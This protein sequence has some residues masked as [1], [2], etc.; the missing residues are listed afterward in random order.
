M[1]D[2]QKRLVREGH[3]DERGAAFCATATQLPGGDRGMVL[4]CVKGN[5]LNI[6]DVDMRNNVK[7]LL[8]QVELK[9]VQN[10]KIRTPLF[11]EVLRFEYQGAV[12]SFKNFLK[13]RPALDVIEEESRKQ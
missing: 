11:I 10:L 8:Y 3:C 4:L 1:S 12:F 6:H 13:V 7:D 9:K 2:F 5:I